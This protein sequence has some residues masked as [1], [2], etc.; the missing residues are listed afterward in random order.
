MILGR[1]VG[2]LW[3]ARRD[4]GLDG[5]KLLIIK[6]HG[7]YDPPFPVAHVIAVDTLGA[8]VGE[9]VVVCMGE[10]ARK[11]LGGSHLPIDAAVMAIVDNID[12]PNRPANGKEHGKE[13]RRAGA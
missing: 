11:S 4:A 8:G 1:V 9:D 13:A 5:R 3:A 10:P 12:Q 2:E 7:W 6:P